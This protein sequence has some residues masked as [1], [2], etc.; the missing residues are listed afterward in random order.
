MKVEAGYLVRYA[1]ERFNERTA[2]FVE[3]W[4]IFLR[5]SK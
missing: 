4:R 5:A 3:R 2:V 1:A